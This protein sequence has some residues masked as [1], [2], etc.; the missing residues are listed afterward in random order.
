MQKALVDPGTD[1][2]PGSV[3]CDYDYDCEIKQT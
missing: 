2:G 1:I 3:D